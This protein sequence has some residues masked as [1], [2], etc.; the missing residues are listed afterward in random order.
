MK[1]RNITA[2]TGVFLSACQAT[3][4]ETDHPARIV[5]PDESSRAELRAVVR[6]AVGI[7]VLLADDALVDS[8]LLVIENWPA[9]TMANPVPQGREMGMPIVFRLVKVGADCV[10][11]RQ[12][13]KQRFRLPNIQCEPE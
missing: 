3:T 9:G 6:E 2:L 5:G 1:P 13:D 7:D 10:L 4:A 12:A 11:V 8:S